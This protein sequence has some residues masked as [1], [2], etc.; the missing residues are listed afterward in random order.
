[1]LI[2]FAHLKLTGKA[3]YKI[4]TGLIHHVWRNTDWADCFEKPHEETPEQI[5]TILASGWRVLI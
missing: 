4:F 3:K 2:T 5:K 1:M